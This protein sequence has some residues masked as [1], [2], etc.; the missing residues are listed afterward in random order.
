M[1]QNPSSATAETELYVDHT[2][3]SMP[4]Q[5]A[6]ELASE[7]AEARRLADRYRLPFLDLAH[8]N[9]DHDLFRTI[10]A[11]LMLRYGFVPF[12]RDGQT[13]VIVISDPT[14]LPMLDELGMLLGTPIRAMVAAP[15]AIQAI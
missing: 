9:I 13:L 1:D 10:P 15:S 6:A 7:V 4:Q 2:E 8:F 11:E 12:G 14:D 5:S 3:H